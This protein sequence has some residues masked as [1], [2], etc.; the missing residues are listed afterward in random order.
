MVILA[1][2]LLAAVLLALVYLTGGHVHNFHAIWVLLAVILISAPALAI[3]FTAPM[4]DLDGNPFTN[5]KGQPVGATLGS[6]AENALLAAYPDEGSL[7]GE[8]KVK[9]FVLARKI[10]EAKNVEL[11]A[12]DVALIKKLIAKDFAGSLVT[13]EAWSLLDPASVP[14]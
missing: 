6:V 2:L 14:K 13:G 10:H 8:E 4:V 9:R 12:E 1:I 5:D 11:S 3:D 7:P